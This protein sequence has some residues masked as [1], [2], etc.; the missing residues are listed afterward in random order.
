MEARNLVTA[1]EIIENDN[2]LMPTMNGSPR[3]KK[4]PLPT[5]INALV[6]KNKSARNLSLNRIP[7]ALIAVFLIFSIYMLVIELYKDPLLAFISSCVLITSFYLLFMARNATW[8]IYAHAFMSG[9]LFL[10]VKNWQENKQSLV[11]NICIGIL[12]GLSFLSKGPVAFY[13]LLLPFILSWVIFIDPLVF[14]KYWK[15]LI[16]SLFIAFLVGGSWPIYILL[17]SEPELMASSKVEVNAWISHHVRPFYQY[18][19]FPFQSGI[20]GLLILVTFAY[21]YM[22]SRVEL[23]KYKFFLSWVFISVVLLSI[24]PEKKERYLLP[25]LIPMAILVGNYLH[26][27]YKSQLENRLTKADKLIVWI[28]A[29]LFFMVSL[30]FPFYLY[31]NGVDGPLLNF[32]IFIN[33]AIC[34]LFIVGLFK[35]RLA[36][37][38]FG[39]VLL[40]SSASIFFIPAVPKIFY[41]NPKYDELM[42]LDERQDYDFNLYSTKVRPEFI[43]ATE[44][45]VDTIYQKENVFIAP[46]E[47]D[48]ILLSNDLLEMSNFDEM[49]KEIHLFDTLYYDPKTMNNYFFAYRVTNN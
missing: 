15:G 2:W 43:W 45:K 38:F 30:G 12:L 46:E 20:W 26:Y 16:L 32:S 42:H 17:N 11:L 6:V 34:M 29:T 37:L 47:D 1:R 48:Y 44:R 35:L 9:A 31:F 13:S 10:W 36:Y 41:K 7:N 27:L 23:G 8:D 21:N 28:N 40:V 5:W 19:S 25:V 33:L 49:A 39:T 22:K 14:K 4:P 3:Y 18:W 24:I